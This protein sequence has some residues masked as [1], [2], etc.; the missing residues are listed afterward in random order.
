MK[1][2]ILIA[3]TLL[4][5]I[6]TTPCFATS[7]LSSPE[8]VDKIS[9]LSSYKDE[10]KIPTENVNSNN[11]IKIP[12]SNQLDAVVDSTPYDYKYSNNMGGFYKASNDAVARIINH[13]LSKA[14][15]IPL[16]NPYWL[17]AI[18]AV[19]YNYTS[20]HK[21][22]LF[23]FPV[24]EDSIKNDKDYF[25]KYNWKEAERITDS[26]TILKRTGGA[27][28][29][30]Q[31]ESFYGSN[32]NGII[33]EELGTI[34]FEGPGNR[35]DCSMELQDSG[36]NFRWV[37]ASKADRW[38]LCDSLNIIVDIYDKSILNKGYLI[39]KD[40]SYAQAVYMMWAH[41]RGMSILNKLDYSI[42]V[43][44][45]IEHLNDLKTLIYDKKP[46][47][48]SRQS[49]L[50]PLINQIANYAESDT[51]PVMCLASYII[52]EARMTGEW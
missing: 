12:N 17:L 34:G 8:N 41:N 9:L 24:D 45:I 52:V 46:N 35:Q 16:K 21:D 20:I 51:Y 49:Y 38:S 26:A 47:R 36:Q 28:G 44:K 27:I 4:Q 15:H 50:M 10:L 42:K 40:N 31:C 1:Y 6:F 23:T 43:D 5:H 30:F 2:K 13:Y 48:F 14:S 18:M 29:P 22:F 7:L 32:S 39:Q 37:K 25:L 11:K 3:L 19:E 33:P